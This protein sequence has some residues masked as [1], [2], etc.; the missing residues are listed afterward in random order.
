MLL[1]PLSARSVAWIDSN[2]K[3]GWR[4]FG[5][6][7]ALTL[8]RVSAEAREENRAV[9]STP[10]AEPDSAPKKVRR[11]RIAE[12]GRRLERAIRH[13]LRFVRNVPIREGARSPERGSRETGDWR[14]F[15]GRERI[16]NTTAGPQRPERQAENN[17]DNGGRNND[18]ARFSPNVEAIHPVRA[19]PAE[20]FGGDSV[21]ISPPIV[22]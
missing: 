10:A 14:R 2:Q 4:G 15:G 9:R 18:V 6:S 22:T 20:A 17:L 3:Q 13:T 5:S 19:A 16:H 11:R 1:L 8:R 12:A 21:R 7:S